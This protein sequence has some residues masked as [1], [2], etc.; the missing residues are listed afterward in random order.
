MMIKETHLTNQVWYRLCGLFEMSQTNMDLRK[1]NVNLEGTKK[2]T[3]VGTRH[4]SF[5]MGKG[6]GKVLDGK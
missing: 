2:P 6:R 4:H 1:Y 5:S 3:V